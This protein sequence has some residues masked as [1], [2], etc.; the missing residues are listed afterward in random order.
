M[1]RLGIILLMATVSWGADV[2]LTDAVKNGDVKAVRALLA[3]HIDVQCVEAD[4]STALY[5]AA[6][7][8]VWK[9][10]TC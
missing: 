9:S 2:R 4:G 6:R 5:W 8:D 7:R 3:Q 1:Q 10:Q